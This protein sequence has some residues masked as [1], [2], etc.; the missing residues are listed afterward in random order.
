[1]GGHPIIFGV[2]AASLE[3]SFNHRVIEKQTLKISRERIQH[4]RQ[5]TVPLYTGLCNAQEPKLPTL[6]ERDLAFSSYS[7]IS[8]CSV[9]D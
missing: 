3:K 4:K 1:M 5:Q 9:L 2:T 6:E 7:V 8:G